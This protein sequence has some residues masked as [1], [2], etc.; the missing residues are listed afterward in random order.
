MVRH[1]QP[2]VHM[3]TYI[4]IHRTSTPSTVVEFVHCSVKDAAYHKQLHPLPIAPPPPCS[5][6]HPLGGQVC[7]G[8]S[9]GVCHFHN[10]YS[11]VHH[12][13]SR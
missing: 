12:Q 1:G 7:S 6:T 3:M 10:M 13:L 11:D 4:E 2:S 9:E 5:P 8:D